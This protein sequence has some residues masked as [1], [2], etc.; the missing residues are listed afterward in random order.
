MLG[1]VFKGHRKLALQSFDDPVPGDDDVVV[2]MKA[3]GF[4]GS[5]LHHYR[6]APGASLAA[7]SPGFLA[8]HGLSPESP[9]I[10]GHEPCGV[11]AELGRNVD[12]RAFRPGDRV[13][14]YHY[15]GCRHCDP[16]RNGWVQMC[17]RGSTVF[18]HTAHGGHAPFMRVP[19]RSLIHLPAEIGYRAGAAISCGTGTAFG[20]LE[21]ME[22][23]ERDTLAVFGL[24]PVGQSAIQLAR[25]MGAR[26]FAV[27]VCSDR[28]ERARQLG[29]TQAVNSREA[30][31]VEA[32]LQWTAGRGATV[33]I[34][35]S[36]VAAAR[37]A[38]VRCTANWGRIAF[39]GVG[40]EVTLNVWSDLMMRQ[41]SIIGHW[42]FSDVGM[43]R[44]VR[45]VADH[46]IDLDQQFS[47]RWQ[48]A[49]AEQAYRQFDSQTAG[50]A[51]F[52]F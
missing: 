40:G 13:M 35:C 22:I 34:D 11:I 50:K 4:C 28:V 14:V 16:C 33:A 20:A 49:Q 5:D 23:S 19:A 8:E 12:R 39:V 3:S 1:V 45:F 26:T 9:V 10:A 29:A 37:L 41:R 15:D 48:L 31:A 30:D 21:R 43:A 32:I 6:G 42:T 17:E 25:A 46:G 7:K 2:E 38:A 44:C 27:D 51:C 47:N 24:G 18:G 52:E 36:G